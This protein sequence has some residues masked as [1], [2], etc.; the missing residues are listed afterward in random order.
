MLTLELTATTSFDAT[1]QVDLSSATYDATT[2]IWSFSAPLIGRVPLW[3]FQPLGG[4]SDVWIQEIAPTELP[5]APDF[6]LLLPSTQ[7]QSYATL[8]TQGVL[9]NVVVPQGSFLQL[10]TVGTSGVITMQLYGFGGDRYAD[11]TCCH[12]LAPAFTQGGGGGN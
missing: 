7:S 8:P 12:Q 2:Q 3:T 9:W 4:A 6:T 10:A 1:T 5:G 11:L